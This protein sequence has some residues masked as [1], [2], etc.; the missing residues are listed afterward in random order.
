MHQQSLLARS[1]NSDSIGSERSVRES[2]RNHHRDHLDVVAREG[3]KSPRTACRSNA[4]YF[5]D[6]HPLSTPI[7]PKQL[8]AT[9]ATALHS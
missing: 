1:L 5:Y 6:K 8:F 2:L 3:L 7:S 9:S 4:G